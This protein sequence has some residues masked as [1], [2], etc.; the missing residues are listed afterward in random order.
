GRPPFKAATHVDTVLQVLSQDPLPPRILNPKVDVDLEKVALKC[1][2]KR[3][4]LRS[5]SAAALAEDLRRYRAGHPVSA[6]SASLRER[7]QRELGHSAHDAP[8]RP[9][10][11]G[12]MILGAFIFCSHLATSLML[13]AGLPEALCYWGPRTVLLLSVVPLFLRYRPHAA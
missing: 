3:P 7:L 6:R 9:W 13:L 12:L 5:A 4:E 1:L 11:L 8:L 10:G 2:E